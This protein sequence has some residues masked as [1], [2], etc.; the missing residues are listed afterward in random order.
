MKAVSFVL[1]ATLSTSAL[2]DDAECNKNYQA[3]MNACADKA[4]SERCMQVCGSGRQICAGAELRR[5]ATTLEMHYRS[6]AMP[7]P[8]RR[9]IEGRGVHLSGASS[10]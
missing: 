6:A 2:A 4:S 1:L 8:L 5:N 3:C 10:Q 7:Q 9:E